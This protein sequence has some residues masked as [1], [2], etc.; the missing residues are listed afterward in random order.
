M[1]ITEYNCNDDDHK[2]AIAGFFDGVARFLMAGVEIAA[3]WR[4]PI[5]GGRTSLM[6]PSTKQE[7]YTYQ[8]LQMYAQNLK[9]D[10]LQVTYEDP[11]FPFV[12]YDQKQMTVVVSGRAITSQPVIATMLLP[13]M[14]QFTLLDA[15]SFDAPATS[16]IPIRLVEK[17]FDVTVSE[18]GCTFKVL[19]YQTIMLR[20]KNDDNTTVRAFT[21][22]Q[23]V[24]Y[25]AD[26]NKIVVESEEKIKVAI[27]NLQGILM[28]EKSGDKKLEM[29]MLKGGVYLLRIVSGNKVYTGKVLVNT[30]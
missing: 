4:V 21:G 5:N 23:G 30:P 15:K 16:N 20:F 10:I 2:L 19:P 29:E 26:R 6:Y 14:E 12:T 8:I 25:Y 13:E 1:C 28:I 24:Q 27:Y 18:T 3:Q 11:I 7:Q 9:G 22:N 17:D